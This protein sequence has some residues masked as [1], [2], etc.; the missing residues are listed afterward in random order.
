MGA[1]LAIVGDTWRQ[2]IHQW[3]LLVLIV[4][5][6]L[7]TLALVAFPQVREAP[8][9]SKF[10]GMRTQEDVAQ[11]GLE[12]GWQGLY[13]DALRDELGLDEEIKSGSKELNDILDE[14]DKVDFKIK[15]LES[16]EPNNPELKE[17][18]Q[19]RRALARERDFKNQ[20]LKELRETVRNQVNETIE[21]RTTGMSKMQKGVEYWLA[22][23]SYA[24]F[25]LSMLGFIAACAVYIPN[26]LETGS[27]DLVLSKPIRR[28]QLYLG[29]YVGGLGLYSVALALAYIVVFVGI[30][31]ISGIWH[32]AFFGGLPMT[33]FSLAL[34]YSIVAWVGLWTRSTAMSMVIGYVYYLVID[35]AIGHLG[36][37]PF[38]GDYPAIEKFSQVLE[39]SF[40][41]FVWLRESAEAAVMEVIVFPWHHLIVGLL[42]LLVCLGTSYNRFRIND[43]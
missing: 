36:S 10:L 43:Y 29:K 33:I 20:Q 21:K 32:W 3:V 18:V 23:A 40:P 41:S 5:L 15:R 38:I 31:L 4:M 16:A 6:G 8:D 1:F 12:G 42:W 34:L 25:L 27:V 37:V 2:S 7:M 13:A 9:G 17:L 26:M 11:S 39:Y 28:W 22:G 30:G 35:T 24:I 14:Y 19:R